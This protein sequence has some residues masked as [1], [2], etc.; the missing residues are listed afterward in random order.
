MIRKV[1]RGFVQI[2]YGLVFLK[3]L[4]HYLSVTIYFTHGC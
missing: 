2:C 4:E 1:L 3:V